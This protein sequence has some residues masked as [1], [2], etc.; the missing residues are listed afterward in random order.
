M[1]RL[2]LAAL[3]ALA[4]PAAGAEELYAQRGQWTI[5]W[6]P[7]TM[8]CRAVRDY[9]TTRFSIGF[10]GTQGEPLLKVNLSDPAWEALPEGARKDIAA[11]FGVREP[12]E[13]SMTG[14]AGLTL[15]APAR[16]QLAGV[17]IDEFKAEMVM[18]WSAGETELGRFTLDG[19]RVAFDTM[20]A[21]Q[22][23]PR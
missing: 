15:T 10:D 3:I 7:E 23:V 1:R 17:F 20:S 13:L 11:Q 8:G 19:S 9:G 18:V 14:G 2:A 4:A 21:C 22:Q 16:A 12:W 5:S 6:F